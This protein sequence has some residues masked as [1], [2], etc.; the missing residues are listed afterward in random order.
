MIAEGNHIVTAITRADNNT[1]LPPDIATKRVDYSVQSSL[2]EALKGQDVLIITMAVMAP[3]DTQN[4]LIEAAA[5]A[6]VQWILPN[7]WGSDTTHP[8]I[9]RN[10]ITTA[11]IKTHEYI[12]K[13]GKSNW[14]GIVNNQ[15]WEWSLGGG[16]YGIDITNQKAKFYDD[17]IAKTVTTTWKRV[18][19]AVTKLLSL[20]IVGELSLQ[21]FKN[22]NVYISSFYLSQREMLD[23]VQRNTGTTDDDWEITSESVEQVIEKAYEEFKRG[24]FRALVK[25]IYGGNFIP[26]GGNDYILTKETLNKKLGFLDEDLDE[27]TKR[28]IEY[29][30]VHK[31]IH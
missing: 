13:L 25:M 1:I 20:P 8:A 6:G 7:E 22:K 21:D 5:E 30:K 24:D 16:Y 27:A 28:A 10:P 11:R 3:P 12:E 17:G 23:A 4:K 18:G 2:V 15:W 19:F 26:N 29:S 14:I 9:L 31:S